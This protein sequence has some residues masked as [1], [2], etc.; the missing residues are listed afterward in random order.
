MGHKSIKQIEKI[1]NKLLFKTKNYLTQTGKKEIT[2]LIHLTLNSQILRTS[3]SQAHF[4]FKRSLPLTRQYGHQTNSSTHPFV[5]LQ[6]IQIFPYIQISCTSKLQNYPHTALQYQESNK[7]HPHETHS[8][9]KFQRS[10]K[11]GHWIDIHC[12]QP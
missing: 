4:C 3:D 1:Q 5:L 6:A 8:P 12:C 11:T 10:E 2:A 7:H 9:G